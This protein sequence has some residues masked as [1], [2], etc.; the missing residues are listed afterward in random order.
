MK[1]NTVQ[2][3]QNNKTAFGAIKPSA[4]A[5]NVLFSRLNKLDWYLEFKEAKAS[6]EKNIIDILLDKG[7]N[8]RLEAVFRSPEGL[9]LKEKEN[10]FS[11]LLKLNPMRF[12]R[13]MC[14]KANNLST[15]Y[16]K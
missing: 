2:N 13:K 15:K 1:I 7:S 12:I 3:I 11:S 8:N 10:Y 4:K 5:E 6:Q 9:I 14:A 16:N